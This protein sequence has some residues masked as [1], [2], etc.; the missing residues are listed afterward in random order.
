LHYIAEII[1]E[2]TEKPGKQ[3]M[4]HHEGSTI[5]CFITK[6]L[7]QEQKSLI[8]YPWRLRMFLIT[9]KSLKLL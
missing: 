6:E 1:P 3:N 5:N 8:I 9:Q 2:N 4:G 7:I